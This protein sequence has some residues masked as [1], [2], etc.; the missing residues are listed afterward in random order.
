MYKVPSII[1]TFSIVHLRK[2]AMAPPISARTLHDDH[3]NIHIS[4]IS[5]V[6]QLPRRRSHSYVLPK[7]HIGT[8]IACR[9]EGTLRPSRSAALLD[10]VEV[11]RNRCMDLKFTTVLI[12][13]SFCSLQAIVS[14]AMD[15]APGLVAGAVFNTLVYLLGIKILL[16]GLTWEGVASSWVLG[17]LSWAAFGPK[18]YSLVCIYFIVGSLVRRSFGSCL[19]LRRIY[20]ESPN[21]YNFLF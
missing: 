3:S 8:A 5:V 6:Q 21:T 13:P 18:S 19:Q 4:A 14:A 15:P 7:I 11:R 9:R 1:P 17:T 16:R 2:S 20:Y 10:N 12:L